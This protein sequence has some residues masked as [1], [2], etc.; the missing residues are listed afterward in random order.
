VLGNH[1]KNE[2]QE[3]S[4]RNRSARDMRISQKAEENHMTGDKQDR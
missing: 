3:H 1:Q 4:A 2:A